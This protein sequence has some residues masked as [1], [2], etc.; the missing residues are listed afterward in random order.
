MEILNYLP[1]LIWALGFLWLNEWAEKW[2]AERF[3]YSY[4]EHRR[5]GKEYGSSVG[6]VWLIGCI[7]FL[8]IGMSIK[9]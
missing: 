5:R 8:I 2:K 6:K 3:G 9:N 1:L 4:E 7:V